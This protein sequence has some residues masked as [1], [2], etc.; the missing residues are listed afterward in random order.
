MIGIYGGTFDPVHYGHLLTALEV[1]ECFSLDELRL[2]PC[3]RPPHRAPP[4]AA[5][6]VR[7]QMLKLAVTNT[8]VFVIDKRELSREGPSYMIDTLKSIR[9]EVA[10]EPLL[11][12]IGADGFKHLTRW[13]QWQGL[14]DFA[15][16]VVMSRPGEEHNVLNENGFLKNRYTDSKAA[17]KNKPNGTLFF[18]NVTPLGIS[19]TQIRKIIASNGNPEFLLPDSVVEFIRTNKLYHSLK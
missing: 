9:E 3:S 12:F 5:A 17:L 7:L 14:F 2:I 18:Q 15:H 8:P 6:R 4:M 10:E 11:L 19:A 16:I 1:S 13:F